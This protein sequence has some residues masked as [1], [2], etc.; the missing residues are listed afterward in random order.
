MTINREQWLTQASH[1]MMEW[2]EETGYIT[3]HPYRVSCGFPSRSALSAKSRRIG[4]CWDVIAS[5][6]SIGEIFISPLLDSPLDVLQTLIHELVHHVVGCEHGHKGPFKRCAKA[7]GLEG[8]M[9]ATHAGEA[10]TTRLNALSDKLGPYP[11][12]RINP[13]AKKK[14][15]G[16]R[17]LKILCPACGWTGR[18]TR[19]WVDIGLPT[20]VCGETIVEAV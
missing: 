5:Q 2:L 7:I 16:T 8:K 15:E 1:T 6:E 3:I 10:L 17:L 19:Q 12:G 18:T 14:K 9:T 20:C 13:S 4:E 11:H